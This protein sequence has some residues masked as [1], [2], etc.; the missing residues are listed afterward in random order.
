M[1]KVRVMSQKMNEVIKGPLKYSNT[2]IYMC[3][4]VRPLGTDNHLSPHGLPLVLAVEHFCWCLKEQKGVLRGPVL[5]LLISVTLLL[6]QRPSVL[7]PTPLPSP[8]TLLFLWY[9]TKNNWTILG[10]AVQLSNQRGIQKNSP[11]GLSNFFYAS[12]L[13]LCFMAVR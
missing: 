3:V 10:V 11:S 4:C 13:P 5:P 12:S 8:G 6:P 7:L 2:H 9:P 1:V